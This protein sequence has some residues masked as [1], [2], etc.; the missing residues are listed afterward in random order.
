MF[1]L[2]YYLLK[3]QEFFIERNANLVVIVQ[4]ACNMSYLNDN[5]LLCNQ[6]LQGHLHAFVKKWFVLNEVVHESE[7]V[8]EVVEY[9]AMSRLVSH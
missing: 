5:D 9:C 8:F 2:L 7:L 6:S 3:H 1:K 4:I